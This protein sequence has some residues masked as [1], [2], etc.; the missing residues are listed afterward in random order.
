MLASPRRWFIASLALLLAGAVAYS[1]GDGATSPATTSTPAARTATPVATSAAPT[2]TTEAREGA[3]P[4]LTAREHEVAQAI[5]PTFPLI[6]P[7]LRS[8]DLGEINFGGRRDEIPALINIGTL[9]QEVMAP[10]L[11]PDEPVISIE[12]NGEARAYPIQILLRHELVNDVGG[13]VPVLTLLL[14][15]VQLRHRLRPSRGWRRGSYLRR[16]RSTAHERP[17]HVR[18]SDGNALAVDHRRGNR[19]QRCRPTADLL[20]LADRLVA[21]LPRRLP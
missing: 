4:P 19:W 3:G 6:D 16:L 10:F 2:P 13:G 18:P 17:D 15:A 20:T 5:F 7:T 9:T 11:V 21:G 14:S 12:I 1:G 8:I